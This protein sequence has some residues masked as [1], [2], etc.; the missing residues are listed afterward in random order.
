[1]NIDDLNDKR[2]E[3]LI[4]IRGINDWIR[5]NPYTDPNFYEMAD[6]FMEY[7]HLSSQYMTELFHGDPVYIEEN[8][9]KRRANGY[10]VLK[11]ADL[12]DVDQE[13][14]TMLKLRGVI[15]FDL[16][17]SIPQGFSTTETVDRG[18][19]IVNSSFFKENEDAR[20]LLTN[21][22][23]SA[24]TGSYGYGVST[25]DFDAKKELI[26]KIAGVKNFIW[27]MKRDDSDFCFENAYEMHFIDDTMEFF[28]KEDFVCEDADIIYGMVDYIHQNSIFR[29]DD[30]QSEYGMGI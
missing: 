4:R 13:L 27:Q 2:D 5:N 15:P 29:Q 12:W 16:Q 22:H 19:P 24:I 1:M 23:Y 9:Q 20:N 30:L 17:E 14:R 6:C 28:S 8:G 7:A 3:F 26:A 25:M 21:L 18:L 10:D 11:L